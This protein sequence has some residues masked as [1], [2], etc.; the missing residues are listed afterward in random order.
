MSL[1]KNPN[2]FPNPKKYAADIDDDGSSSHQYF[3]VWKIHKTCPNFFECSMYLKY[4][5]DGVH[6]TTSYNW[7][8]VKEFKGVLFRILLVLI[9]IRKPGTHYCSLLYRYSSIN[10]KNLASGIYEKSSFSFYMIN[11]IFL[12]KV[13]VSRLQV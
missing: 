7:T 4:N 6:K 10:E 12:Y 9:L 5:R 8:E 11:L 2:R 13:R 3:F 1:K